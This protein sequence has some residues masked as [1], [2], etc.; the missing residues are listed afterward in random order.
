MA[1]RTRA[2]GGARP[3]E[4]S[5]LV[6]LSSRPAKEPGQAASRANRP[7]ATE[8]STLPGLGKNLRR[9]PAGLGLHEADKVVPGK[10]ESGRLQDHGVKQA[11]AVCREGKPKLDTFF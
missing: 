10:E 6:D 2:G 7:R 9:D 11:T 4:S 3:R 1:T 8:L 5:L